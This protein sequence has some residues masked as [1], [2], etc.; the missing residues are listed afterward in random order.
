V[1]VAMSGIS[2]TAGSAAGTVVADGGT[3]TFTAG[4]ATLDLNGGAGADSYIYHSSDALLTI[5]NFSST[6]G[7]TLI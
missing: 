7:D 6:K 5:E 4:K 1:F 2:L 3:N